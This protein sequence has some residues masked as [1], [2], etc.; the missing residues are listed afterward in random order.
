MRDCIFS[1]FNGTLDTCIRIPTCGVVR[2]LDGSLKI[3]YSRFLTYIKLLLQKLDKPELDRH[4]SICTVLSEIFSI[5]GGD[6]DARYTST[7]S[8]ALPLT[9]TV[10]FSPGLGGSGETLMECMSIMV[11]MSVATIRTVQ[12]E[13][14]SERTTNLVF[15]LLR[16]MRSTSQRNLGSQG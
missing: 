4:I 6:N 3:W 16:S 9:V 2:I 13:P 11:G 8:V 5:M 10:R 12:V 7:R 1:F 14:R 15:P